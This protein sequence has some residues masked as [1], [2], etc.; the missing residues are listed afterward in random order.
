MKKCIHNVINTKNKFSKEIKKKLRDFTNVTF[1]HSSS[2]LASQLSE[3]KFMRGLL[4]LD[5][6]KTYQYKFSFANV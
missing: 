4:F 6:W 2:N 5:L 3:L 1:Y